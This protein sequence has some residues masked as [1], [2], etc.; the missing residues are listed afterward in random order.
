[1]VPA[2]AA[3]VPGV[4][5]QW[6]HRRVPHCPRP[7]PVVRPSIVLNIGKGIIGIQRF[8]PGNVKQNLCVACMGLLTF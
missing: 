6:W 7:L 2:E 8:F 3:A 4:C 1:M 5:S